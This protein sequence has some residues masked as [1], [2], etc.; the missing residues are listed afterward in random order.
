MAT[1]EKKRKPENATP[2]NQQTDAAITSLEEEARTYKALHTPNFPERMFGPTI[3]D[4]E[5]DAVLYMGQD[6][7]YGTTLTEDQGGGD[8]S[9]KIVLAV[10][11]LNEG[12]SDG[13]NVELSDPNLRYG[14]GLTIY[15]KTDTGR[16]QTFE[17]VSKNESSDKKIK[18]SERKATT[19]SP[20]KAVSVVEINADVIEL[21]A[22]NG[23]VNIIAGIDPTLPSYGDDVDKDKPN[24][25]YVGVSLIGGG[26]PE[27][28]ILNNPNN[29]RGLQP[30][31]KATNLERRL[32]EMADRIG[33]VNN[34]LLDVIKAQ[35]VLELA[36]AVHVHPV[37]VPG[38]TLPSIDLALAIGVVK[39][40]KDIFNVLKNIT[41][42]YNQI[43]LSI[44]MSS[45]STGGFASQFNK[46]N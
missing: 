44:N 2:A 41:A 10:G 21:K 46:T 23:G 11:F 7:R 18:N 5:A 27:T 30:I 34:V 4:G 20:Q 35:K 37:V 16:N 8:F 32:R 6:E 17:S 24:V 36:L 25:N 12:K 38:S 31:A 15:Q 22:R 14:A 45:I 19:A 1:I 29:Y 33:D 42:K 40:P 43:A 3:I 13:A 28:D 26:N 39:T 9:N